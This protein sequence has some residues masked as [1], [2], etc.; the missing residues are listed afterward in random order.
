MKNVV[1]MICSPRKLGNS[2]IMVKEIS[3]QMNVP[4]TLKL[5]R[6]HDMDILPCK[7]CYHCLFENGQ[8]VLNDD[9]IKAL[10]VVVE[11][12]ALIVAVPT[13]FLSANSMLKRFLDRCLAGYAHIDNLWRKPAIGI[14]PSIWSGAM[15][16]TRRWSPISSPC[17][18]GLVGTVNSLYGSEAFCVH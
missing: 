13:Y 9:F 7:G 12:D 15:S 18:R 8:C 16:T 10:N 17:S 6:L 1:G 11:A 3:R 14:G 4:H 5:I 2:E